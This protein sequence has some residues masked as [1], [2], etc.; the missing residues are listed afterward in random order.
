MGREAIAEPKHERAG[1]APGSQPKK[2]D[3]LREMLHRPEYRRALVFCGIIGTPVSLI[4]FWF[5]VL[6]HELE[7]LIWV[8][9]PH[10]LGWSDPPWW[11][12]LPLALVSGAV[13]GLAVLRFPGRGGHIPAAGLHAG[14]ASKAAIPGVAL[15]ALAS[16]PLGAALGPEAP[17]IALGGG[18]ALAFRDL[19]RPPRPRRARHCSVRPAPR[20]PFPRSSAARWSV[21]CC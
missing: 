7:N 12:P 5:L 3:Q 8:D 13:V 4:A 21:P 9:W 14:G 10:D 11:W 15:A 1:T 17:L 2:A 20:P 19:A 18:L 16:L 6:L